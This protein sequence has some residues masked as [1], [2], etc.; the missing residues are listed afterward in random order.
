MTGRLLLSIA[1]LA[2]TPVPAQ[3]R[4]GG[5]FEDLGR[6]TDRLLGDLSR[7]LA[8]ALRDLERELEKLDRYEAPEILPNGDILIRRKRSP[9]APDAPDAPDAPPRHG[10]GDTEETE[11]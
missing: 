4:G 10:G 3:D 1:L 11:T 5:F 6:E 9:Q 2:A 7:R 8:P